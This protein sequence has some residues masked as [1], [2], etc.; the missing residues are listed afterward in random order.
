M[1]LTMKTNEEPNDSTNL[2][3]GWTFA[4]LLVNSTNLS[5]IERIFDGNTI[6]TC[7]AYF[8]GCPPSFL[9]GLRG[10]EGANVG[11]PWLGGA[12]AGVFYIKSSGT[13]GAD[14]EGV[15]TIGAYSG[16]ACIRGVC[17]RGAC[18]IGN[19]IGG[20]GI[21]G[22]CGS[23]H[24]PSESSIWCSRLLV[25][26]TSEMLISSCLRLRVILDKVLYYRFAH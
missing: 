14:T 11:D 19:Y 10:T 15:C 6:L 23:A 12:Y 3:G 1:T 20:T 13:K 26:L 24:K 18:D 17:I 5:T 25:E 21:G 2:W 7:S 9:T 4:S 22:I 8:P 16:G